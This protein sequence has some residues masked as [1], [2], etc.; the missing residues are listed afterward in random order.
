[1]KSSENAVPCPGESENIGDL[2]PSTSTLK[3][4]LL[5][6]HM[7]DLQ[8]SG[9]TA[10]TIARSGIYS[11]KSENE[12]RSLLAWSGRGGS[13]PVPSMVIPY[14][15]SDS[16]VRLKPDEP[17][18][19][20]DGRVVKY[21]APVGQESRIYIPHS[22]QPQVTTTGEA[23]YLTEGEKTALAG[24]QCG[25]PMVAA[26]GVW[27]FHDVAAKLAAREEG[28]N[29]FR[30][31]SDL[32]PFVNADRSVVI[33]F[34]S[35]ID[36]NPNIVSAAATLIQMCRDAGAV[37]EI[38]YL[39]NGPVKKMGVDDLLVQLDGNSDK[40]REALGKERRPTNS[41]AVL[42]WL[43]ERS[44]GWSK[45]ELK[46]QLRRAAE[47]ASRVEERDAY[48]NWLEKTT[49]RLSPPKTWVTE[50]RQLRKYRRKTKLLSSSGWLSAPGF[51]VVSGGDY[52][53]VWKQNEDDDRPPKPIA[54]E[55][56][57]ISGVG[58][59]EQGEMHAEVQWSYGGKK[60][61]VVVPRAVVMGPNIL[62]LA[63]SGAP[64]TQS[65]RNSLQVFLSRQES[66]NFTEK[67]L[68]SAYRKQGWT[69][70]LCGYVLGNTVIGVEGR[71][72]GDADKRYVDA[73]QP[74]GDH[75]QYIDIVRSAIARSFVVEAHWA[76]GYCGPLLRLVGA[77]SF[78]TS[79]WG[80]SHGGKSAAQAL[81]VSPWG[82]PSGLMLTGDATP[83]ALEGALGQ[84]RDGILW[85]D[86]SQQTRYRAVLDALA[87]QIAGGTG[88][89][90]GTRTGGIRP[91][92]DWLCLALVSGERPLCRVN[93]PLGAKNRT[94]E[95]HAVP[96]GDREFAGQLHRKLDQH[97]GMTGPEF[98]HALTERL[99]V[100]G[101]HKFRETHAEIVGTLD[102]IR[103]EVVEQVGL[104][105]FADLAARMWVL[106]EDQTSARESAIR[107]GR[108]ILTLARSDADMQIDP[109]EAA[110]E[111]I[112][113]WVAE[114]AES[115][116]EG[117]PRRVGAILDSAPEANGR[118]VAAIL[119]GP[120]LDVARRAEFDLD[121]VVRGLR[122]RNLLVTDKGNKLQRKTPS[123][124]TDRPRA[125]W[126]VMPGPGDGDSPPTGGVSPSIPRGEGQERGQR[127]Q[128]LSQGDSSNCPHVPA[129]PAEDNLGKKR[130]SEKEMRSEKVED[131]EIPRVCA[132]NAGTAGTQG[133]GEREEEEG[134]AI[135]TYTYTPPSHI[136]KAVP[137]TVPLLSPRGQCVMT[138]AADSPQDV[139]FELVASL[140]QLPQVAEAVSASDCVALDLETTG[141][142]AILHRPRLLQIGLPD[143]RI[144]LVDLF[145][146]GGLGP[147]GGALNTSTVLGHNLQFDLGF[148][149]RHF[150]VRPTGVR[151]T[152]TTSKLLDGGL[153]LR[154]KGY[155]TLA[156]VMERHLGITLDKTEQKSD[157]SGELTQ[158]QLQ[159]AAL[160]VA[161][162]HQLDDVLS[163]QIAETGLDRVLDLENALVPVVVDMELGGVGLDR[164]AWSLLIDERR[165]EA[166]DLGERLRRD[167]G[168]QN[169]DSSKQVVEALNRIGI[170][171]KRSSSEA[172]AAFQ[173]RPEIQQ[174]QRFRTLIG[175]VRNTGASVLEACDQY[176]DN[177]VRASFNPTAAPTGRFGC[178]KPNLL[179]LPKTPE[180]RRCI[181]P[182]PGMSYVCADYAA[183]ELRVLAEVTGDERLRQV[184]RE[185]G[186]PH[187]LT[188]S[189]LL[190]KQPDEVTKAERQRA[191]AVNFGFAFGMG[192]ARFVSYALSDFGVEFT[193][194]E[195]RRFKRQ[196]LRAYRQVAQWQKG[197]GRT[198]SLETRTAAGRL[199]RLS[200]K[201]R[202]YTE[203]LNTP[204]QG[205][206]ADGMKKAMIV[207]HPRLAELGARMVLCIHDE[208]L[209]E[210]PKERA[211]EVKNVVVSGMVEGLSEFVNSVPIEVEADVRKTWAG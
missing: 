135:N 205:T 170:P 10:G 130:N 196:Y 209:V 131:G 197:I 167:L 61:R 204:I 28:R 199:R 98:L 64:V 162:L 110:Y 144:F 69:P 15:N 43:V 100:D 153:H 97:H 179:A 150:A 103:S 185:G 47:I 3:Y 44:E 165:Q 29:E 194:S 17:R 50:F 67:D 16:Y 106:G 6:N 74:R 108:E 37:T 158:Q 34:D 26:P 136:P 76:A 36:T 94:L 95:L 5:D 87:Y 148:L 211:D 14:P 140:E 175:F 168:I 125:Y 42:E 176:R 157:W 113:G 86:D 96:F 207:L 58:R 151:C 117:A 4:R 206:A 88:R 40:L 128:L 9:L 154:T 163:G 208:L 189:L 184:F 27:S 11:T 46:L 178:R 78:L 56:I 55:P 112:V 202:G 155:H 53:G 188:A 19:N 149:A 13:V 114:V 143:G 187:R 85:I 83:T 7:K 31:H 75:G 182:A 62:D 93:T 127:N 180:V 8:S 90:R 70:D 124:G 116:E 81:A 159:Y 23:L 92:R 132:T 186:D 200:E 32:R 120:L 63:A 177:R 60:S 210:A 102:P 134:N 109:I 79:V 41:E 123:L 107:M 105:V 166:Q 65:N 133:D 101:A 152:M 12:A 35:D 191:K 66:R 201:N 48:L 49:Q 99:N 54:A 33:A 77:R 164:V 80:N 82:R 91:L 119:R 111:A 39:P 193:L 203:R 195:A 71:Y 138:G 192:A 160:D 122:E 172:L 51:I 38:T 156:G 45:K 181:V 72:V 141:L 25:L 174:L 169:L 145:K 173:G 142:D 118:R 52:K 21:E 190:K 115:F 126:I 59:D 129:V 89:A 22:A 146:L 121:A 183:I 24:C 198:K 104:L 137:A 139:R 171:T 57:N 20:R 18:K 73:L 2:E 30:L 161:H 147:L 68:F 84:R 1:M